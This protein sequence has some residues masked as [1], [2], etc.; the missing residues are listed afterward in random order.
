MGLG[1]VAA[2]ETDLN[3]G[4]LTERGKSWGAH[5]GKVC[6]RVWRMSE[7]AGAVTDRVV[8]S[9]SDEE[10]ELG[11]LRKLVVEV[12]KADRWLESRFRMEGR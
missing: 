12:E 11:A 4:G 5:G 9:F 2:E 3:L 7:A 1:V 10:R 8:G 6:I